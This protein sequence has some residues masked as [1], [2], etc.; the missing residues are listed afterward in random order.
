MM[1]TNLFVAHHHRSFSF[2]SQQQ[3][4]PRRPSRR[5][6]GFF[7]SSPPPP[8]SFVA[9]FAVV[10]FLLRKWRFWERDE[11]QT[12]KFDLGCETD[13][14]RETKRKETD[15]MRD[16]SAGTRTHGHKKW[17]TT[18]SRV[19]SARWAFITCEMTFLIHYSYYYYY[20]AETTR[21]AR[22]QTSFGWFRIHLLLFVSLPQ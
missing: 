9:V 11:S 16:K 4:R 19:R 21:R 12:G 15:V 18:R 22:F 13:A 1:P 5:R 14:L 20:S 3:R 8:P 10:V 7:S 2:L 17:K 6:R